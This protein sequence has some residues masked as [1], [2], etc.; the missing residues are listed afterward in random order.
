VEVNLDQATQEKITAAVLDKSVSVGDARHHA[1][2]SGIKL[3]LF[4]TC[5]IIYALHF[6]PY[7]YRELYLTM[8]LAEK[9]SIHVDD[10]VDLHPDL[11]V[12][13]GRGSFLGHNPGASILAAIPYWFSLPL[14]NR[15]APV[16][17][18]KPGQNIS[19]QY[20]TP[21]PDRL[22]F[23]Q[24]VR[25]RG[26]DVHLGAAAAITAVFFMAPLTALSVVVIFVL[27]RRLRFPFRIALWLALLYAF[28]TPMFFRT[29]TISLNLLVALL[30]V[31]AFALVWSPDASREREPLRYILA[32]LIVGYTIVTDYTGIILVFGLGGLALLLQLQ[33]KPFWPALKRCLW[34]VAGTIPPGLFM[35]GWQWYCYGSPWTPAQLVMPKKFFMGYP[36]AR[37]VGWPLPEALWGLLFDPLYGL[38]VFAPIF[39]LIL[40]HF[41][42]LRRKQNLVP[43]R[44]AAFAWFVLAGTWIFCSCIHYVLRFQWMDGFR[45]MIPVVPFLFLLLADVL[46]R[47]PR[48]LTFLVAFAAVFETWCLSMVRENPM[49][50]IL[51]VVLHGFELPSLTTLANAAPQYFPFLSQGVSPTPLFV[52]TGVLIWAI[53]SVPAPGKPL[54]EWREAEFDMRRR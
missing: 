37:G 47:I 42:L 19:E 31:F 15:I 5:W 1:G 32:G 45:Y 3:R 7:I 48:W 20:N 50:S 29:A 14:V 46:V 51:R 9:H 23:Y 24:K 8:S 10:Y 25:A 39:V 40:Y 28:G 43:G 44:V 38:F 36:S 53:W 33:E 30:G 17:P 13:P 12:M 54:L 22:Q 26:L 2:L 4:L 18:P 41:V 27:L 49:E 6:S 21:Y 35:L 34:L 52:V 16:R 11:F